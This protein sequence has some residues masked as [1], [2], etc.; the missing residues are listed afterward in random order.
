MASEKR[1]KTVTLIGMSGVGK[2]SIALQLSKKLQRP[3]IDT[4]KLLVRQLH[5]S[6]QEYLKIHSAHELLLEEESVILNFKARRASVVA[7]GGSVV[8]SEKAMS[9]LKAFSLVLYLKDSYENI[10]ARTTLKDRGIFSPNHQNFEEIFKE[11][12]SLYDRYADLTIALPFPF[13]PDQIIRDIIRKLP[14]QCLERNAT[15][16]LPKTS[17][18]Q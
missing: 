6:L 13:N 9:H 7:T 2:S 14:Q 4:D 3:C 5:C 18:S 10:V 1:L 17:R 8:Y 15:P 11:R 12:L 16:S